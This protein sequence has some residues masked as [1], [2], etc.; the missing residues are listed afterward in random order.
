MSASKRV[1][2]LVRRQRYHQAALRHLEW[3][4]EKFEAERLSGRTWEGIMAAERE[5]LRATEVA[6][7]A[8]RQLRAAEFDVVTFAGSR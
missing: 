1:P 5:M 4:T 7:I 6:R 8:E 3:A 2:K